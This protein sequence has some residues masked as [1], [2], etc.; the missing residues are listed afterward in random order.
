MFFS[1]SFF[2]EP[3]SVSERG[4]LHIISLM[5]LIRRQKSQPCIEIVFPDGL[6]SAGK[7]P[8][9]ERKTGLIIS[10]ESHDYSVEDV[11]DKRFDGS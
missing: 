8:L 5:I 3:C 1:E 10:E 11:Q 6:R 2:S 7:R 9:D 4:R